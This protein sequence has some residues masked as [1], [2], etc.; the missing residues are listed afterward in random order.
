MKKSVIKTVLTS[1]GLMAFFGCT[2]PSSVLNLPPEVRGEKISDNSFEVYDP[3]V[4]ILFVIDNSGSM[5]P[6]QS[7]LS[8]NINRFI[9]NFIQKNGLD[10]HI[11]VLTTDM[12]NSSWGNGV[13]CGILAGTP[14]FVER[15]TPNFSQVLSRNMIVGTDGSASEESF[16]P[17]IAALTAPNLTGANAGFYRPKS[18]L[19]IVFVTDAED[20]SRMS[21]DS[22][23][24]F[25]VG[26]KGDTSKVSVYG[27]IV[28]TS[29]RNCDRDEPNTVPTRIEALL[30]KVSN[31]GN[32]TLNLCSADYG[33][34][35][36]LLGDDLLSRVSSLIYLNR[37]PVSATI[38]VTFGSQNIPFGAETGFLYDS[39][40]N[41]II[42]GE[43][44]VW[45]VQPAGT[46][47]QVSYEA[48]R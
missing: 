32:N 24:N 27:A 2:N 30:A 23:F 41:A 25:L 9:Q 14:K 33:D 28:P 26:L 47:V 40:R 45:S 13:C 39:F 48:E 38:R 6:H 20:Q 15:T 34:K 46:K 29:E 19:A 42:L 10:F 18:H 43:K 1:I 36:A 44:I 4:D 8:R 7:N 5:Q 16:A 17:V 3:S 37:R 21:V 11:G 35:L 12:D 22:F 31:A